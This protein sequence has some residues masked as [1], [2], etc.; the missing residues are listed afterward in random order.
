MH[1]LYNKLI[2]RVDL[3]SPGMKGLRFACRMRSPVELIFA[4][5]YILIVK[6]KR[7]T[8]LSVPSSKMRF[9]K[10]NILVYDIYIL[11][12]VFQSALFSTLHV[13]SVIIKHNSFI[14]VLQ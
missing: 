7:T 13:L 5:H 1:N 14:I 12:E 6:R 9:F 8:E 10:Y 3:L 11:I 2:A 4:P